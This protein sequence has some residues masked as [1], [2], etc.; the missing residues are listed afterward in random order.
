MFFE[1][2]LKR[3]GSLY[4]INSLDDIEAPEVLA[5]GRGRRFSTKIRFPPGLARCTFVFSTFALAAP[6]ER[7]RVKVWL[8]VVVAG[9]TRQNES[10]QANWSARD[11]VEAAA[12]G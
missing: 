10:S 7:F 8:L 5:V 4:V 6:E 12:S 3:S 9:F 2:D 1:K 11:R